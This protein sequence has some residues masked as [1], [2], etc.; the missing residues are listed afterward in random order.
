[1]RRHGCLGNCVQF[2]IKK[3]FDQI[4]GERIVSAALHTLAKF[5]CER[6]VLHRNIQFVSVLNCKLQLYPCALWRIYTREAPAINYKNRTR[7][8]F[9]SQAIG[10]RSTEKKYDFR[11][12]RFMR[13]AHANNKELIIGF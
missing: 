2:L 11:L 13:A 5:M 7:R 6:G 3:A 4:K 12:M 9:V 10:A 1:M 8:A